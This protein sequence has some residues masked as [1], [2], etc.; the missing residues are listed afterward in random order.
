MELDAAL[1]RLAAKGDAGAA[2]AAF[3]PFL[4]HRHFLAEDLASTPG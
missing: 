4:E 3:I 2:T 1:Q